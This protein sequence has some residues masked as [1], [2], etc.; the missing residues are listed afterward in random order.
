MTEIV[1][2]ARNATPPVAQ[3]PRLMDAVHEASRVRHFSR[4][5]EAS[6]AAWIRR[7]VI[8]NDRRHPSELGIQHVRRFLSG[9]AVRGR[10]SAST[11]NQASAALTFLYSDVLR[12]PLPELDG[13]RLA[14][15]SKS[16]PVVLSRKE[17]QQVL[18]ELK[19]MP[20]LMALAMYGSGMRLMEVA[21]LRVKDVDVAGREIYVRRGKGSKDRRT[22]LSESLAHFLP[23]HLERVRRLHSRDVEA[24]GGRVPL[25]DALDRKYPN[26][27]ADWRWQYVFPAT[28]VY[29]DVKTGMIARHHYHAT[30]IQRAV[31]VAVATAGITKAASCHTFRHSFATHLIEDGYDIRTVQTLLGHSDVRTTMIYTHVLNRG[32]LGVRSPADRLTG[33]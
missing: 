33:W 17:V 21:T 12:E 13:L 25:P 4:R 1:T 24:G 29:R 26:A 15:R 9:L 31:K 18:A 20:K 6:Y 28:R 16:L 27:G 2:L 23:R 30:A 8:A 32:G 14:K 3:P 11:Q 7:F 10:V 5:T 19:G 22:V